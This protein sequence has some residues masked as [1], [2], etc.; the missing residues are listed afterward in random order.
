[1]KLGK[2]YLNANIF[3][4]NLSENVQMLHIIG[5]NFYIIDHFHSRINVEILRVYWNRASNVKVIIQFGLEEE[6]K[7]KSISN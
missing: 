4:R 5:M 6:E 1:M 2:S 7:E 3:L